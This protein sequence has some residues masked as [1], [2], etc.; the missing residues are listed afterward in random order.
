MGHYTARSGIDYVSVDDPIYGRSDVNY[1]T[2]QT[3]Y[4]GVGDVDPYL[5]HQ[6]L[7]SF[8]WPLSLRLPNRRRSMPC[9]PPS[10]L[11]EHKT[12]RIPALR[13]ATGPLQLGEPHQVF[14]LGLHDLAARK[15]LDAAKPAGWRYLVQEGDKVRRFRR[16]GCLPVPATNTF[17]PLSMKAALS[18]RRRMRF[19]P[20]VSCPR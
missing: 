6:I 13:N 8:R 1:A 5:L 9:I 2:L 3:A 19:D 12:F 16:D 17:S 4:K 14:T 18:A 10:G 11:S 15:G 7:R 20:R